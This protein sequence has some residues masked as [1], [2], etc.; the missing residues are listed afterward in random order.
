MIR[1]EKYQSLKKGDNYG[2]WYARAVTS[3]TM[4][5]DNLVEHMASHG[6]PY[7]EGTIAGVITDMVACIRELALDGKAVKI[8]DLAIFAL[9]IET[10]PANTAAEW[11]PNTNINRTYLKA[12]GTGDFSTATIKTKAKF[13]EADEYGV[14]D[15]TNSTTDEDTTSTD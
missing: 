6:T 7:S 5:L 8:P 12:R 15:T 13:K 14:D 3:E 2:K 10:T 9:G 11:K 4:S 1:Y